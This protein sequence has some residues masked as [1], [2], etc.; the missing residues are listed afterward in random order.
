MPRIGFY[1]RV[2][3]GGGQGVKV[4]TRL[5]QIIGSVLTI[6]LFL[7]FITPAGSVPLPDLGGGGIKPTPTPS[8]SATASSSSSASPTP[9]PTPSSSPS[10]TASPTP[11]PTQ[12]TTSTPSPTSTPR[13]L[14][15]SVPPLNS[16]QEV[17]V[18]QKFSNLPPQLIKVPTE[19]KSSDRK[20][21]IS[22]N[23]WCKNPKE[24]LNNVYLG[25]DCKISLVPL[26]E[27]SRN[28][29]YEVQTLAF[30]PTR[31]VV[32]NLPK[33]RSFTIIVRKPNGT[34]REIGVAKSDSS[35][36]LFIPPLTLGQTNRSISVELRPSSGKSYTF[37]LRSLR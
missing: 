16:S 22:V 17:S 12:S 6:F 8:P 10:P 21:T 34:Q 2:E 13:L 36:N 1:L 7:G 37:T 4:K 35:G 29:L 9:T 33:D 25:G 15:K 5:G 14:L 24:I 31:V 27:I 3:F 28:K 26:S 20:K 30:T 32:K 18:P 23:S 19:W 11:T